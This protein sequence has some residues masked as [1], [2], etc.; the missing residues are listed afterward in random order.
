VKHLTLAKKRR[1]KRQ[2]RKVMGAGRKKC[3]QEANNI[4]KTN[5]KNA[6]LQ[7][8]DTGWI[9]RSQSEGSQRQRSLVG[10]VMT[11]KGRNPQRIVAK[12]KARFGTVGGE[13]GETERSQGRG[14]GTAGLEACG[15]VLSGGGFR[16]TVWQRRKREE[17]F[18][19]EA[20]EGRQ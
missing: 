20:G 13:A 15:G 14:R 2:E 8:V 17:N 9:I 19:K 16:I 10:E 6:V 1:K 4:V 12:E 5:W 18:G 11:G 3:L 7:C